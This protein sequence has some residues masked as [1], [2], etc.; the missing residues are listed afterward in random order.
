MKV[1]LSTI[2]LKNGKIPP[3][4]ELELCNFRNDKTL[5]HLLPEMEYLEYVSVAEGLRK[6]FKSRDSETGVFLLECNKETMSP[7]ELMSLGLCTIMEILKTGR[8]NRDLVIPPKEL[9][10]GNT[11]GKEDI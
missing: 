4:V 8:K 1:T 7:G 9:C 2:D 6:V 5:L 10:W 3:I 11:A